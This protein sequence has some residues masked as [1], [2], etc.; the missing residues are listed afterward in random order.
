M[1]TFPDIVEVHSELLRLPEGDELIA[2]VRDRDGNM[3]TAGGLRKVHG[4]LRDNGYE[5]VTASNGLW[6]LAGRVKRS[7]REDWR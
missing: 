7:S 5:W 2:S 6:R 1:T 3:I 4:W